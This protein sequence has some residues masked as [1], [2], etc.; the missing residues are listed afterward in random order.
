MEDKSTRKLKKL[1]LVVTL[2]LL[3]ESILG[4]IGLLLSILYF[5]L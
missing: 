3:A 5:C 2:A 1:I 4:P